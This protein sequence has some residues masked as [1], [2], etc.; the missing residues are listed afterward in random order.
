MPGVLDRVG[1]GGSRD[2]LKTFSPRQMRFM[3]ALQPWD[4]PM[5]YGDAARDEMRCKEQLLKNFFQNVEVVLRTASPRAPS[6]CDVRP[7]FTFMTTPQ[8][9]R[10][11]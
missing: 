1:A 5:T 10:E 9:R 2:S 11:V 7:S 6:R 4:K 3:F 8:D